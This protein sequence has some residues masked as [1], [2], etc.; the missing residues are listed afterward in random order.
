MISE[1]SVRNQLDDLPRGS[2]IKDEMV[3]IVDDEA[4]VFSVAKRKLNK[5]DGDIESP[6]ERRNSII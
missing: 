4:E 5:S 2:Y 3:G 6:L 1:N